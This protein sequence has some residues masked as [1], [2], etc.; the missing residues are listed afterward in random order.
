MKLLTRIQCAA[1]MAATA[2]AYAPVSLGMEYVQ[3]EYIFS[4]DGKVTERVIGGSGASCTEATKGMENLLGQVVKREL[5]PE[6]S[7]EEITDNDNELN[8]NQ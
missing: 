1:A 3:I 7:E 5:L 8:V 4:K 2:L 6:Y